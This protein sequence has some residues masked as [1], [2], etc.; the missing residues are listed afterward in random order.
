MC[1]TELLYDADRPPLIELL[2]IE[3]RATNATVSEYKNYPEEWTVVPIDVSS[4]ESVSRAMQ[5]VCRVKTVSRE[6]AARYGLFNPESTED[7][8]P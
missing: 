6:E 5:E 7:N 2:P 8:P 4:S 3:T 1:P